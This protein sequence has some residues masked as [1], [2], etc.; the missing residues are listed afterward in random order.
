MTDTDLFER[1]RTLTADVLDVAT[2]QVV[3]D[4][5]FAEELGVDSLDLV[6]LVEALESAFG[7]SIDD[8]EL[9]DVTTVGEAYA[10]LAGKVVA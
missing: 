9:A 6:E 1:F 4:A 3:T 2:E 8:E 10:L 5:R 7:V